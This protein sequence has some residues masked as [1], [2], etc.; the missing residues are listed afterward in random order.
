MADAFTFDKQ[1]AERIERSVLYTE[2]LVT[3]NRPRPRPAKSIPPRRTLARRFALR[4]EL[5][6]G[7]T[8]KALPLFW[9]EDLRRWLIVAGRVTEKETD[10]FLADPIVGHLPQNAQITAVH[11]GG[12][13][14]GALTGIEWVE[15]SFPDPND[16]KDLPRHSVV[17]I[18]QVAR[19]N[20]SDPTLVS[21]GLNAAS[22]PPGLSGQWFDCLFLL[23][24][25][26]DGADPPQTVVPAIARPPCWALYDPADGTPELGDLWGPVNGD[27]RLKKR[28]LFE[29]TVSFD[30]AIDINVTIGAKDDHSTCDCEVKSA[31][32]TVHDVKRTWEF[33]WAVVRVDADNERVLIRHLNQDLVFAHLKSESPV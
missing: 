24:D 15:V 9:D 3:G 26:I 1:S 16:A 4:E 7:E 5:R 8:A 21:P 17:S 2:G 30:H 11:F 22:N 10:V 29:R 23:D 31:S 28:P 25:Y 6:F 33:G 20:K 13:G 32:A 27:H 19:E 14:W 18:L 12:L